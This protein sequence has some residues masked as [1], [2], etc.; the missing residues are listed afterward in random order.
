MAKKKS[1]NPFLLFGSYV[2]GV[3]LVLLKLFWFM[4]RS[5]TP[6]LQTLQNQFRLTGV[7]FNI[8]GEFFI[9]LIYFIVGFFLGY[10]IHL[11]VRMW[12]RKVMR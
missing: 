5:N 4:N 12:F 9:T 2:G 1:F 11:L 7:G 8:F 3:S 10:G 6:F